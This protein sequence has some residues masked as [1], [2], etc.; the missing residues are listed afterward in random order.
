MEEE[1]NDGEALLTPDVTVIKVL[2]CDVFGIIV[3][4]KNQA[5]TIQYFVSLLFINNF[6]CQE[7]LYYNLI[8]YVVGV[9]FTTSI[10]AYAV[11]QTYQVDRYFSV[12]NI[13]SKQCMIA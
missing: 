13:K 2:P 10:V 5:S 12:P 7:S 4:I 8:V 6:L 9:I 1:E 11:Y 3:R